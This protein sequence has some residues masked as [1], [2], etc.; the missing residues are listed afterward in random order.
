MKTL[1]GL[2]G[3]VVA[4]LLVACGGDDSGGGLGDGCTTDA[5]CKGVRICIDQECVDPSGGDGDRD[6]GAGGTSGMGSGNGGTGGRVDDPELEAA[7]SADCMARDAA[8]CEMD[9]SLDQCLGQ[10]LV[11]DEINHGYCLEENTDRYSCLAEGGYTCVSGYPQ[12]ES[13]CIAELTAMSQCQQLV[14]CRM[15]C[16][17][18]GGDCAPEGEECVTECQETQNG[19][20]DGICGHYYSQLLYC[21]TQDQAQCDGDRPAIGNCGPQVAEIADCIALRNTDCEGYCWAAE[22]LGCGSADCATDCQAKIDN[23]SCGSYY[24]N[25]IDCSIG[26][27]EL[28]VSCEGGELVPNETACMSQIDQFDTCMAME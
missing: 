4:V 6:S 18:F 21:W 12:P 5:Q 9:L 13:T 7:C 3:A 16:D 1:I 22:M 10:C 25:V 19:F 20:A 27:R 14:P 11:I 28:N 24:R 2:G 17:R 26:S 23:S 8:D 15:Y